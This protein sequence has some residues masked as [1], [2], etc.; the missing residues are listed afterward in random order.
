MIEKLLA[1]QT[2]DAKLKKIE[3]E[4]AESEERKKAVTAKKVIDSSVDN[5]NRLDVKAATLMNEYELLCAEESKLQEFYAEFKNAVDGMESENEATYLSKKIEEVTAKIKSLSEKIN[6]VSSEIQAVLKEYVG[7]RNSVKNA[8]AQ[9]NENGKKY[10]ELKESKK[11]DREE[12][13]KELEQLKKSVDDA[14]ME[15]YLAKRKNFYPVVYEVSGESC[16][17]CLIELPLSERN[18]LK[19]GEI[20]E[21]SNCGR[22]L[23]QKKQ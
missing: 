14:L 15:K 7:A 8:Q 13:E 22:L 2:A 20:V 23:Y 10:S 12:A 19:S 5:I 6:A 17:A 4:L 16:G 3:K 9:Y 1:Y 11:A 18:K 21:C